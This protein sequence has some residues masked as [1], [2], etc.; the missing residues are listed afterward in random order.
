[1]NQ[2]KYWRNERGLTQVELALASGVGRWAIQ[3]MENG[4]RTPT[5]SEI[6][7]IAEILGIPIKRLFSNHDDSLQKEDEMDQ[8]KSSQKTKNWNS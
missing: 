7:A 6:K 3:L 8:G 4:V 5:E 2:L 1:M